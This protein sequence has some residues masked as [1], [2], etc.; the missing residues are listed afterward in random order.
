MFFNNENKIP[1]TSR[2]CGYKQYNFQT[3]RYRRSKD[4]IEDQNEDTIKEMIN[5]IPNEEATLK[6]AINL[7]PYRKDD[8]AYATKLHV[9]ITLFLPLLSDLSILEI[10]KPKEEDI[11]EINRLRNMVVSLAKIINLQKELKELKNEMYLLQQAFNPVTGSTYEY[12]LSHAKLATK[13]NNYE[14]NYAREIN[15]FKASLQLKKQL[16]RNENGYEISHY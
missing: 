14:N 16:K 4:Q 5:K 2:D 15:L 3:K 10:Y 7:E 1:I 9:L 13:L 8:Y 12:L 11:L 6:L